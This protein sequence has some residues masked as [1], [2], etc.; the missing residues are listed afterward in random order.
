MF[1]G[2]KAVTRRWA[3]YAESKE[4]VGTRMSVRQK[5]ALGAQFTILR[6]NAGAVTRQLNAAANANRSR[7]LW[8][9][10]CLTQERRRG[11]R[12]IGNSNDG[13]RRSHDISSH[14]PFP[15]S[16]DS[17]QTS[18]PSVTSAIRSLR[19]TQTS[20]VHIFPINTSIRNAVA[21]QLLFVSC[22]CF[23]LSRMHFGASARPAC[24][25]TAVTGS[26]VGQLASERGRAAS[27][28]ASHGAS[29]SRR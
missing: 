3:C 11:R 16:V 21:L 13:A 2:T 22:F 6:R 7:W 4:S 28:H 17:S 12:V 18:E 8:K 14:L 29:N 24:S 23:F 15:P 20:L 19:P 9:V 10:D 1:L 5:L 27:P 26:A 25:W